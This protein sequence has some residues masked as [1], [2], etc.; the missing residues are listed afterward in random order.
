[1]KLVYFNLLGT[2]CQRVLR[3]STAQT[4]AQYSAFN[5]PFSARGD[6][7]AGRW[8]KGCSRRHP[9]TRPAIVLQNDLHLRGVA[10][11]DDIHPAVFQKLSSDVIHKT[12][13]LPIV[14]AARVSPQKIPLERRIRG[15]SH[16]GVINSL[17]RLKRI[18]VS[19]RQSCI[20]VEFSLGLRFSTCCKDSDEHE[21]KNPTRLPE[22]RDTAGHYNPPWDLR[23]KK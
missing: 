13:V 17:D 10:A 20:T 11:K 15:G 14:E 2:F 21:K 9:L 22:N 3:R 6:Q 4:I 7:I 16:I 8:V 12:P 18:G 5:I 19:S 23:N 1:V